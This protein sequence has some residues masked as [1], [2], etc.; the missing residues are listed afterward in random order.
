MAGKTLRLTYYFY[1]QK[2]EGTFANQ[3]VFTTNFP[4]YFD[5]NTLT[6]RPAG[7]EVVSDFHGLGKNPSISDLDIEK[8]NGDKLS[9]T[10]Y[11]NYANDDN[12]S[13]GLSLNNTVIHDGVFLKI[14][15]L[16]VNRITDDDGRSAISILLDTS[17][18]DFEIGILDNIEIIA[19]KFSPPFTPWLYYGTQFN[20]DIEGEPPIQRRAALALNFGEDRVVS[21]MGGI[22]ET[23]VPAQALQARYF[24]DQ[25][26][27]DTFVPVLIPFPSAFFVPVSAVSS[28]FNRHF[29]TLDVLDGAGSLAL[30]SSTTFTIASITIGDSFAGVNSAAATTYRADAIRT[31]N[32]REMNYNTK[33]YKEKK[34][35]QRARYYIG[36]EKNIRYKN[37]Y[38]GIVDSFDIFMKNFVMPPSELL[39]GSE[40]EKVDFI[41]YAY[42]D[43]STD[44]VATVDRI[45]DSTSALKSLIDSDEFY[46]LG[47]EEDSS[48]DEDSA[49]PLNA[50]V[51][52]V[53]NTIYSKMR[54]D[55][56]S[57]FSGGKQN[58]RY[59]S[60]ILNGMHF[61]S[62]E[63]N[64]NDALTTSQNAH[65]SLLELRQFDR[66]GES[67]QAQ[68]FSMGTILNPQSSVVTEKRF[69]SYR[70]LGSQ[71][72]TQNYL[73][74]QDSN[75]DFYG[76]QFLNVLARSA[77]LTI[78][79]EESLYE[80]KGVDGPLLIQ[81]ANETIAEASNVVP[82]DSDIDGDGVTSILDRLYYL[83]RNYRINDDI[84]VSDKFYGPFGE[85]GS[86]MRYWRKVCPHG[87]LYTFKGR[88]VSGQ[89]KNSGNYLLK[90]EIV[91]ED[92]EGE[93]V[94]YD[95][96]SQFNEIDVYVENN[97]RSNTSFYTP[98]SNL[99]EFQGR[100]FHPAYLKKL[101]LTN[102]L[103]MSDPEEFTAWMRVTFPTALDLLDLAESD[104][105]DK[106]LIV[107]RSNLGET[108]PSSSNTGLFQPPSLFTAFGE[109]SSI[110][111]LGGDIQRPAYFKIA[112]SVEYVG[113]HVYFKELESA[114]SVQ[115][116]TGIEP[117]LIFQTL[118][119]PPSSFGTSSQ[120]VPVVIYE[121]E[122]EVALF[123]PTDLYRTYE[124]EVTYRPSGSDDFVQLYKFYSAVAFAVPIQ[125]N[126]KVGRVK[127]V[128]SDPQSFVL[129]KTPSSQLD[130]ESWGGRQFFINH[131]YQSIDDFR[132]AFTFDPN[133]WDVSVYL[134]NVK[135]ATKLLTDPSEWGVM[136]SEFV[137]VN[138]FS[139]SVLFQEE[140]D[141]NKNL[142]TLKATNISGEQQELK[143]GNQ[144][145]IQV[146][147]GPTG[148][149]G[150]EIRNV[151]INN[152]SGQ[153]YERVDCV[154]DSTLHGEDYLMICPTQAFGYVASRSWFLDTENNTSVGGSLFGTRIQGFLTSPYWILDPFAVPSD[155][156][157]KTIRMG[158]NPYDFPVFDVRNSTVVNSN[159]QPYL[160]Y[161]TIGYEVPAPEIGLYRLDSVFSKRTE[162]FTLVMN[163]GDNIVQKF[164][165]Y[166]FKD[167][168]TPDTELS[169]LERNLRKTLPVY[170]GP[171]TQDDIFNSLSGDGTLNVEEQNNTLV[172]LEVNASVSEKTEPI[173]LEAD[174]GAGGGFE[175]FGY[176]DNSGR[177][178]SL[179][180]PVTPY[181]DGSGIGYSQLPLTTGIKNIKFNIPEGS[182][183]QS[184]N[185]VKRSF[186]PDIAMIKG[187][188]AN[189]E[190]SNFGDYILF[191]NSNGNIKQIKALVSQTDCQ[192]WKRP[193]IESSDEKYYESIPV[194]TNYE[195]PII[196][197]DSINDIFYLFVYGIQDQSVNLV[198]FSRKI[199]LKLSQG[200]SEGD[201]VKPEGELEEG[202]EPDNSKTKMGLN[203]DEN[204]WKQFFEGQGNH[205]LPILFNSTPKFDAEITSNGYMFLASMS[206]DD[207]LRILVNTNFGGSEFEPS[208]WYDLGIDLL[209]E[210]GF[211][212]KSLANEKVY[213][214][215]ISHNDRMQGLFLFISTENKLI[216]YRIPDAIVRDLG[217]DPVSRRISEIFQSFANQKKPN[218][219]IGRIDTLDSELIN[220]GNV[221]VEEDF[222]QQLVSVQWLENGECWLFYVDDQNTIKTLR[223]LTQGNTWSTYT[224]V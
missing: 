196:V 213:A 107:I 23:L 219:I 130:V 66:E 79:N 58:N 123:G 61:E 158:N 131:P 59:C 143:V 46:T 197:K 144:I 81:Q 51:A 142:V 140:I 52:N 150:V 95:G 146:V 190:E 139:G 192:Y 154:Y 136:G 195:S 193:G 24:I 156:N 4:F 117:Q 84:V 189:L 137:Q 98:S 63:G 45:Q 65:E 42:D 8:E 87:Q 218:L 38:K 55:I 126:Q 70:D 122:F 115:I 43:N 121:V 62:I 71:V 206:S 222:P 35:I 106:P 22:H 162:R 129:T 221:V 223:S 220:I 67:I 167:R 18:L 163:E 111:L 105:S 164:S 94:E 214:V 171:I 157:S 160:E 212:K 179:Y 108:D 135:K 109:V 89:T 170:T 28:S 138:P 64:E 99:I 9:I 166:K 15:D 29:F 93:I 194:L 47:K 201:Y 116:N 155:L 44:V 85:F 147:N 145:K 49:G 187:T 204:S 128:A 141:T 7:A 119:E 103:P 159:G 77:G 2:R 86:E 30:R 127:F 6:Q 56:I 10:S 91:W 72:F 41:F 132:F 37:I 148:L 199:F 205:I 174:T 96:I 83:Y 57:D 186:V 75:S 120:T 202:Q 100:L 34:I 182:S 39:G 188:S 198:S 31:I 175:P 169:Y 74:I 124:I 68:V 60:I 21:N 210:D 5:E 173:S 209:D 26:T 185:G 82:F 102:I 133:V 73:G 33:S 32:S 25:S 149:E 224:N 110:D 208:G 184:I 40:S 211:L 69:E 92:E 27:S 177:K 88:V 181:G 113:D 180:L 215:S 151:K 11:G 203:P 178:Y 36:L 19:R 13:I 168:D 134:N 20:A 53:L 90:V 78:K 16:V 191:F 161:Q 3:L 152:F 176:K 125:D 48:F 114:D 1:A 104:F 118:G 80:E 217:Q 54:S 200:I 216:Q 183:V 165:F 76:F 50:S 112:Q 12:W 17:N 14:E 172:A 97:A 101:N 153:S 207:E